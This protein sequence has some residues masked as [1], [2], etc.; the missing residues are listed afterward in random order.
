[1]PKPV[2]NLTGDNDG[3]LELRYTNYVK[4]A[5]VKAVREAFGHEATTKDYRYSTT[6]ADSQLAIYRG[7]PKRGPVKY[8]CILVEA[9]V[10][11][12]SISTLGDEM[13]YEVLDEDGLV[14]NYM[15]SGTMNINVRMTVYADTTT[16]RE[17]ITDLLSIYTRFVFID[18]FKKY[19]M[20]YLNIRAGDAGEDIEGDRVLYK[21]EV[22]VTLQTE[23]MQKIDM[24]LYDAVTTINL[25][26]M[27]YGSSS[28]D[29]QKNSV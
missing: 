16:D 13:Y 27:K 9:E 11:D 28:S 1:M 10:G 25:E 18:L 23:F 24:S 3:S 29:L 14:T 6:E 4:N 8:P 19:N 5:F 21:G 26:D 17:K 12:I 22:T 15:Y 7:F 2:I 20:P